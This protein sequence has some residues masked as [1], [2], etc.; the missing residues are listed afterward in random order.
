MVLMAVLEAL[1]PDLLG[2][3]YRLGGERDGCTLNLYCIKP[4]LHLSSKQGLIYNNGT[5]SR[6]SD[7]ILGNVGKY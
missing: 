2:K 5:I 6:Q 7:G 4:R 1:E 3:L